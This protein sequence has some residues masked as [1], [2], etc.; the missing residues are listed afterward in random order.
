MWRL[1]KMTPLQGE[2]ARESN[3]TC[4]DL[5]Q[6]RPGEVSQTN[7]AWTFCGNDKRKAKRC[8]NGHRFSPET[9]L[10]SQWNYSNSWGFRQT[11]SLRCP[12]IELE[13]ELEVQQGLGSLT[14]F[15]DQILW[16]F[17]FIAEILYFTF[18]SDWLPCY[19]NKLLSWMVRQMAGRWCQHSHKEPDIIQ[20]NFVQV[21][22]QATSFLTVST[23]LAT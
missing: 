19:L 21:K 16:S 13:L 20:H 18:N 14:C 8:Q 17:H 6:H 12:V 7:L 10:S 9:S 3:T 15:Y 2:P 1:F 4:I 11:A 5:F 22:N 23:G